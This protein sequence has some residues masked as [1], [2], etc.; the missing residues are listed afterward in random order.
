MHRDALNPSR[1]H[2]M[3]KGA[4]SPGADFWFGCLLLVGL[5]AAGEIAAGRDGDSMAG[6]RAVP[7]SVPTEGRTGFI[8]LSSRQTGV[9]FT[10]RISPD[11]YTTNQIF[12]NGSGVAAG[13]VDGDGR[14]D[15]LFAAID[16][17]N[18][19]YRNLGDWR[20]EDITEAAGVACVGMHSTGVVLADLDGDADLD[21]VV[22]SVG[23]GTHVFLNDGMGRFHESAVLNAGRGGMSMALADADGD[24]SLDLYVCNYRPDT[25]RD[26]P[27]TNFRVSMSNGV[28]RIVS[29]NGRPI[30]Q[31]DLV[32]RFSLT[33][34]RHILEHGE[35]DVFFR[36]DGKAHFF[37]RSFTDGTFRDENGQPLTEPPYDWGLSV[38]F[39]DLNGDR[40][41]DLYVC[42]DFDSIDRIWINDGHGGFRAAPRL[43]FRDTSRFSMGVDV[44]DIDRDGHDDIFVL[45]MRSRQ[46]ARRMTRRDNRVDPTPPGMVENRPQAPRNTL[47]LNRGDGTYAEVAQFAGLD[48]SEWSWT[49]IFIDVDL[50]GFEDLLITNGHERDDMDV[51][52]GAR[53][54]AARRSGGLTPLQELNLRRSTP[55]LPAPN[56][57]YRN[58]GGVRF[59]EVGREW[60]FDRE[61]VS[62]GMCVAD[63]DG[64]GDLD[65]VV[66][67]LNGEAGLY[68]NGS[69]LGRVAV[70]LK[71]QG[72]NG[73]G[74][75][76]RIR[77][78]NGAVAEQSQEMISGGRYLSGDQAMRVFASGPKRE[79]M[80]LEVE[81]RS[82]KRSV[83]EGVKANWEYEIA[84]AG[85]GA[86]AGGGAKGPLGSAAPGGGGGKQ[87]QAPLFEDRSELLGHRHHEEEYDDFGRQRLLPRKLSQLGPGVGWVDVNGDGLEDVVIGSGR[88]GRMGVYVN[89]GKG[90]F[91]KETSLELE[92]ERDLSGLVG[93]AGADGKREVLVGTANYED[94][95]AAGASVK[96]Y[97]RGLMRVAVGQGAEGSTGPLALG[98]VDGDGEL[99]LFIGSRAVGGR[100][101]EAGRSRLMKRRQG[102][103][104]EDREGTRGLKAAGLVSGAV[105]TD[106][107]GDGYPELVVACDWGPLRV[108]NNRGGELQEATE[109]WGLGAMKGWWNGVS[110]GD[111]DGDG[112]MDLVGSNWGLNHS[113]RVES[114]RGWRLY[115]GDL[116][117][118][119]GVEMLESGWEPQMKQWVPERDLSVVS[120]AL[121]WVQVKYGSYAAYAR[122]GVE[123]VLGERMRQA[124]VLE[125]NWLETTVWLNRGDH[126]ERGR[127]PREAQYSPAFGVS[128]GDVDGDGR[129]DVFLSQNFYAEAAE[130]SREDAGRGLLLRGDGKG[131]FEA[132]SGERSGIEVYGE[133]RGSALGDYDQDG[134]VDLV[135]GQN[136]GR[137][138]LFHNV[139]ARAGLRVGLKGPEANPEGI[140]A[141]MRL[142]FEGGWGAAREVHGGNGYWS[143]DGGV[144][145]LGTPE[146]PRRIEVRWPGGKTVLAEVPAGARQIAVDTQGRVTKLP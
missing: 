121:P 55:R 49:A 15:L 80:R 89:D 19:L 119:G 28:P 100:Y 66:N 137:T 9:T 126:F 18:A 62:Q 91:E 118:D 141:V 8:L 58:E 5:V 83:V 125:V 60:G 30:T 97:Q 32:G 94:G 82:G 127:L 22:N 56:L 146:A 12:L 112:R 79:G 3:G 2:R 111:L 96:G 61:G 7:L 115:F 59:E 50:D 23:R 67:E 63:L 76:A 52:H 101:P 134:R 13:D 144:E 51:D 86:E 75:G 54:E 1:S 116:A 71:G 85:D 138:R 109:A 108:F 129:E 142:E 25:L 4:C 53:I 117:G 6:V 35:A 43:A 93:W 64:D 114:A 132:M 10:N 16:G 78:E 47:H 84:E 36:N 123:E 70:R 27:R 37:P 145:V 41:P 48:A 136:G 81:W 11:V 92:Q 39:R 90:G 29:V 40:A 14:C 106:L 103:W 88:G 68:R 65:V 33:P 122:A 98:D 72:A 45:D 104:E 139:G 135:V 73:E 110:A 140:G 128:I 131:G 44:A 42:N 21:L 69:V 38:L 99:E 87:G 46:H 133:G 74:I 17:R 113:Y 26:Q 20:F 31:P 130:R 24:G 95:Q 57:A 124:G 120:R 143:E 107:D 77:L 105:W 102:R 34:S